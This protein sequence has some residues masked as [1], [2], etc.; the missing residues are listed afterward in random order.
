MAEW[1][2]TTSDAIGVPKS[3]IQNLFTP[4]DTTDSNM[5]VRQM[6]K[7]SSSKGINWTPTVMVNDVTI[8]N[9]P[10]TVYDWIGMLESL[11]Q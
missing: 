4:L 8:I 11:Y 1:S 7:Y 2:Q 5:R 10:Q 3:D 9:N 6:F